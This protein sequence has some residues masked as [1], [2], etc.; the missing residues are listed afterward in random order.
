MIV[1]ETIYN[2]LESASPE[3]Q[4]RFYKGVEHKMDLLTKELEEYRQVLGLK[5]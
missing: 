4:D 5:G 2:L 1:A 3:Q